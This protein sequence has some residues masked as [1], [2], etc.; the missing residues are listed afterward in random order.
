MSEKHLFGVVSTTD[1][2][3]LGP[4]CHT[5]DKPITSLALCGFCGDCAILMEEVTGESVFPQKDEE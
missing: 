4:V 3:W 2:G 1:P 5:C